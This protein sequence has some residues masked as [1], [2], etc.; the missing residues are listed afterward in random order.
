MSSSWL[1]SF[2]V[3]IHFHSSIMDV[4]FTIAVNIIYFITLFISHYVTLSWLLIIRNWLGHLGWLLDI[5]Y[6]NKCKSRAVLMTM[7]IMKLCKNN[8]QVLASKPR[9][10]DN[11]ETFQFLYISQCYVISIWRLTYGFLIPI[12]ITIGFMG[13]FHTHLQK[14]RTLTRQDFFSQYK[15]LNW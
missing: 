7:Y 1:S 9:N 10:W 12:C 4:N 14:W 8:L 2:D 11:D 6:N 13:L 3:L 5:V 15:I